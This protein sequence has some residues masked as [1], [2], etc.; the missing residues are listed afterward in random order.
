MFGDMPSQVRSLARSCGG[1]RKLVGELVS[2]SEK[3]NYRRRPDTIYDKTR[4]RLK[5]PKS[6]IQHK[7]QTAY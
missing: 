6:D 4:S 3:Y 1:V 7:I 5:K 2:D